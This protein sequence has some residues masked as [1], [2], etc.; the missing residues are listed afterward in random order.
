VG[1]L[2]ASESVD[3]RPHGFSAAFNRPLNPP[4]S[5]FERCSWND[6]KINQW[7]QETTATSR[8]VDRKTTVF[9]VG[10]G[11]DASV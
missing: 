4:V 2:I 7:A 8:D 6:A 11:I 5:N 3:Q 10:A 9:W 1:G